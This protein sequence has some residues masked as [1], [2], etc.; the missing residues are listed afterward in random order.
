MRLKEK[1]QKGKIW[2][3][4]NGKINKNGRGGVDQTGKR[5]RNKNKR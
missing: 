4:D 2:T 3:N 5:E 1:G